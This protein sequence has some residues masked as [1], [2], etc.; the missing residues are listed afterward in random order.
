MLIQ[1]CGGLLKPTRTIYM[2]PLLNQKQYQEILWLQCILRWVL[3]SLG[4]IFAF[5]YALDL[6]WWTGLMV[7]LSFFFI[8][9]RI[10]ILEKKVVYVFLW[11]KSP[12]S[13][14]EASFAL[15]VVQDEWYAM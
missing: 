14:L 10:I 7:L 2:L 13:W 6:V 3:S 8:F 4:L 12:K 5:L 9:H 11:D 1:R 15:S